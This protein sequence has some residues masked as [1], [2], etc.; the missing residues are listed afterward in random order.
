MI[1]EKYSYAGVHCTQTQLILMS[2]GCRKNGNKQ[3]QREHLDTYV[4]RTCGLHT[5]TRTYYVRSLFKKTRE[6]SRMNKNHSTL[7][8]RTNQ[9]AT[10]RLKMHTC[11][12]NRIGKARV[13]LQRYEIC[14]P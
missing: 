12:M 9:L 4:L 3:L 10:Y 1:P 2:Y 13:V 14:F 5:H 11:L 8:D 6:M 7:L